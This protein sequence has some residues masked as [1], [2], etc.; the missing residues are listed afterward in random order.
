MERSF[1]HFKVTVEFSV[2][3]YSQDVRTYEDK[4]MSLITEAIN[5]DVDDFRNEVRTSVEQHGDFRAYCPEF[6]NGYPSDDWEGDDIEI[7]ILVVTEEILTT[8]EITYN[9]P[10]AVKLRKQ[11]EGGS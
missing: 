5:E 11:I 4:T 3:G 1:N 6:A 9:D 8:I 7:T 10:R 2:K